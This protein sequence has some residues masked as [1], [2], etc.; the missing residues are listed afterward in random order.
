MASIP[1]A[2]S[3][4]RS[5][6]PGRRGG[7]LRRP[8]DDADPTPGTQHPGGLRERG[9]WV[10]D[11][12]QHIGEHDGVDRFGG[13]REHDGVGLH[14]RRAPRYVGDPEHLRRRVKSDDQ[15]GRRH[16]VDGAEQRTGAP[17]DVDNHASVAHLEPGQQR[18]RAREDDRAP[19]FLVGIDAEGVLGDDVDPAGS[20]RRG[21]VAPALG[22]TGDSQ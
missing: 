9:L 12:E 7:T 17:A 22:F 4:P 20:T 6:R 21:D 8:G 14:C 3:R 18:H 19:Q 13:H 10:G 15:G 2:L 5:T 11:V 16:G 1:S